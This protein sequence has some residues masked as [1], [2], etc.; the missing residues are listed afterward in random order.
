LKKTIAHENVTQ[1]L[2]FI[3]KERLPGLAD[4]PNLGYTEAVIHESM[5]LATIGPTGIFHESS[6]DSEICKYTF[7]EVS[8]L[9]LL[10]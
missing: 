6:C 9:S 4:R 8:V 5:R 3:G 10:Y 1:F 2:L 7:D